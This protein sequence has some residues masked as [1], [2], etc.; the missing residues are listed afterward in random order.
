[1][2]VTNAEIIAWLPGMQALGMTP[3][4]ESISQ[5]AN[6]FTFRPDLRNFIV[7]ISDGEETCGNDPAET[8]EALKE[9]GIDFS[10]HVIGLG[11][12]QPTAAQLQRIADAG[13]GVY[14]DAPNGAAFD[15]AL[16]SVNNDIMDASNNIPPTLTPTPTET[17]PPTAIRGAPDDRRSSTLSLCRRPCHF[18]PASR[19]AAG[20]SVPRAFSPPAPGRPGPGLPRSGRCGCRPAGGCPGLARSEGRTPRG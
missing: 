15:A 10:I 20:P 3:M 8:V 5:A 17:P 16:G 4:T 6:D 1:M 13:G 11:V 12:D 9:I 18:M 2:Y 7:L 19:P 14:Y